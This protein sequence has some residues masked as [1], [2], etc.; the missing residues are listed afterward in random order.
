MSQVNIT[1]WI[2][3]ES[4]DFKRLE[5]YVQVR[6]NINRG[7]EYGVF[8]ADKNGILLQNGEP[9]YAE[10]DGG[11]VGIRYPAKAAN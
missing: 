2:D 3:F 7:I 5:N 11:W 4:S 6:I 8:V 1:R 10:L 9:I